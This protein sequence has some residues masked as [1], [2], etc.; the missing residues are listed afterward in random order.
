MTTSRQSSENPTMTNKRGWLAV[1]D[2]AARAT[3]P[4]RCLR[5]TECNHRAVS[6]LTS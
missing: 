5:E 3:A 1:D 6:W 2:G 4:R